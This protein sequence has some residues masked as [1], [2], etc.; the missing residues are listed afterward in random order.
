MSVKQFPIMISYRGTKGPCP[1]WIPWDLIAPY[2]AQAQINHYQSLEKLASRGG[3]SPIEAFLVMNGRDWR[4]IRVNE[5]LER[6]AAAFLEKAFRDREQ[7]QVEHDL[8]K[9]ALELISITSTRDVERIKKYAATKLLGP[10]EKTAA[11]D[12]NGSTVC[13][14]CKAVVPKADRWDHLCAENRYC[15]CGLEITDALHICRPPMALPGADAVKALEQEVEI[16]KFHLRDKEADATALQKL[17]EGLH[18]R[19]EGKP[20]WVVASNCQTALNYIDFLKPQVDAMRPV[21]EAALKLNRAYT[22]WKT[23]GLGGV[24]MLEAISAYENGLPKNLN[25]AP[26]WV[27]AVQC[28]RCPYLMR[29][30]GPCTKCGYV[31]RPVAE[32]RRCPVCVDRCTCGYTGIPDGGR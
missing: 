18:Q 24:D 10:S 11:E 7:L 29:K 26:E 8:Y 15:A 19:I 23:L 17:S 2:E 30:G 6:Q 27:G 4:D 13:V 28:P 22:N 3:L 1:S 20:D 16:L 25:H 31:E 14:D 5:E 12:G 32:V 21:V 9:G